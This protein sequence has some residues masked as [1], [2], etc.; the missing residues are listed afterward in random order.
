MPNLKAVPAQWSNDPSVVPTPATLAHLETLAGE[1]AKVAA[2]FAKQS[3]HGEGEDEY[4]ESIRL[5]EEIRDRKAMLEPEQTRMRVMYARM[6]NLYFPE[7]LTTG[8]ADHWPEAEKAGRVHVSLNNPHVFVDIPASL[9]SVVPIENY[10]AET[11]EPEDRDKAAR[12]ERLYFEWKAD[13]DFEMKT[14]VACLSKGLYGMTYG[15]VYW[16]DIAGRP[17]ATVIERPDNLY[18]GWGASDYSRIDFAIYCYG[19]SPQ[20][21]EEDYGLAVEPKMF[22]ETY[23]PFVTVRGDAHADPLGTLHP[24]LDARDGHIRDEYEQRQVEVYDYWY[25]KAK[26]TKKGKKVAAEVWNAI[27]V[28]NFLVKN[29]KHTEYEDI[30]YLPLRNTIIPGLPF[31]RPELYDLEQLIREKDERLTNAGQM[32]ASIT[33]GQRWQLVGAEAPDEVPP[34]AVPQPNK[35]AAPGPG[36]ELKALQPFVGT[37][38]VE[39]YLKRLDVEIETLTG[40]NELIL[41][42]APATILGSS[43]AIAALVANY[44][45]R[46]KMKRD[47]LYAWRQRM[48]KTA[49]KVWEK[50]DPK[51]KAIIDG[52]YRIDIR[53]PELTPRDELENSQKAMSLVQNRLWSMR[54][55]MDATGVEDPEDELN[56]IREEQ[57]DAALN[58]AAV[59]S[60]ATLLG[61]LQALGIQPPQASVE[62]AN[63]AARQLNR[64]VPGGQSLNA[65][66]NQGN[67]PAQSLPANA[68]VGGAPATAGSKAVAQSMLQNGETTGR[69]LTQTPLSGGGA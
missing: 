69:I 54:R 13:D 53:P 37:Y 20:A 26:T 12:A 60:Q 49:A 17:T 44:E 1:A 41:G 58:P 65:P 10:V 66:E 38:A 18:V 39:D 14:H 59:T 5:I 22:G 48:W 7:G 4:D 36:N 42:R 32:I 24:E 46:I 33:D 31:G 30:P 45:A 68:Q 67:A 56:V 3:Y 29:E 8:G 52:R 64:P 28:G 27:F 57:T 23:Y 11:S 35:V 25:K 21:V 47:L 6:D 34:N 16:D 63:N 61:T 55:A 51:V 50:K 19:L 2:A 43:K 15:K 62:Q 40:L 9:Q